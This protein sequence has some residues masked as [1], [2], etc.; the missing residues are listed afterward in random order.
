MESQR[1]RSLVAR[2]LPTV[3]PQTIATIDD[4]HS[5][6]DRVHCMYVYLRNLGRDTLVSSGEST[7]VVT[8]GAT[9]LCGHGSPL[10]PLSPPCVTTLPAQATGCQIAIHVQVHR[11]SCEA[12]AD[13]EAQHNLQC[14]TLMVETGEIHEVCELLRAGADTAAINPD[15]LSPL[16]TFDR[17]PRSAM[18][19]AGS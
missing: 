7:C 1:P 16:W 14:T 5:S 12:G 17:P 4:E 15:V 3:S 18:G 8:W 6:V 2:V 11:I 19:T 13:T 9:P 10:P